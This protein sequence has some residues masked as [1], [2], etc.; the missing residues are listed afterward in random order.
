MADTGTINLGGRTRCSWR[1]DDPG[2]RI[3]HSPEEGPG[4]VNLNAAPATVLLS[5]PGIGQ[6][7]VERILDRRS[8]GRPVASLDELAG[9]ISPAAR[10][11]LFAQYS[12]LARVVT[13]APNRL[14]VTATGWVDGQAPRTTIELMTVPLPERLAAIRRRMW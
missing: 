1:V 13:F 9:L 6:E 5:L 4:T 3:N 10:G 7:A 12:E 14:L 8:F 2:A 11:A